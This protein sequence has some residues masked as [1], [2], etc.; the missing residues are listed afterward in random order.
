MQG[1]NCSLS[2]ERENRAETLIAEDP[3]NVRKGR[4]SP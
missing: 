1:L 4:Y 2:A 3:L